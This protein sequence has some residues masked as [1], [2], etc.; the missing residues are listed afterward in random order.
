MARFIAIDNANVVDVLHISM[1]PRPKSD[2]PKAR[3]I[4]V[5]I[6]DATH[7]L[8]QEIEDRDGVLVSEQVRRG[9]ALWL[10]S[11]GVKSA[12]RRVSPRRRA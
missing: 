5:R 11:K 1:T 10:E 8:L 6:H 3:V 9:I 2:N 12:Q 7:A 4:T